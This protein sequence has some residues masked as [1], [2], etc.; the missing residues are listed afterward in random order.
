MNDVM[1]PVAFDKLL[2]WIMEEYKEHKSIF[3]IAESNFFINCK[4]E[5][6]RLWGEKYETALGPA[7]GPHTQ[8]AQNIIAAYLTG[9]RFFELKTIQVMDELDIPKPCIEA[10]HEGYNTEWSTEL[11][12]EEAYQE[13]VK[14]W[15]ILHY[16]K[17][18]FG[19]RNTPESGFIFNMSVGYDL[20]GIKTAKI[21]NFIENLKD[22]EH[23]AFFNQCQREMFGIT[24]EEIR[25]PA[26]ISRSITL[27]TMHGCPPEEQESICRYLI[28][29][30]KLHTYVKLNPTLLGY[31]FVGKT[32]RGLGFTCPLKEESFANDLQYEPAKKMINSLLA[33]AEENGLTFGVKL[34]N[35]LPVRNAKAVLPGDE[36]YMSGKALYPL[37]INLA[38][39][40]YNDFGEKLAISYCGGAEADNIAEIL[41]CGIRP[42]TLATNL[43]KPGG[44]SRL[45]QMAEIEVLTKVPGKI[46]KEKLN[47]LAGAVL[48]SF[49]R[50]EKYSHQLKTAKALPLWDC[51]LASCSSGCPIG[52]DIP[53]YISKVRAG[54]FAEAL[55]IILL[56]NPLPHITGYICE[57]PCRLHC[58]RIDYDTPLQIRELKKTAALKG[59][60]EVLAKITATPAGNKKAAIIGAGP[61][62]LAAAYFL[63]KHGIAVSVFEKESKAGG[64]VRNVIP[65]FRLTEEVIDKDVELIKRTGVEINYNQNVDVDELIKR[66]YEYILLAVGA[67]KSRKLEL[68]GDGNGLISGLDFLKLFKAGKIEQFRGKRV[69]ITGGGNSAMDSARAAMRLPGVKS[70]DLVYRRT[71]K[72]MPADREEFDNAISEGVVFKELLQPVKLA[73]N[74]LYCQ[75]MELDKADDHRRRGVHPSGAETVEMAADLVISAIGEEVDREFLITNGINLINNFNTNRENVYLLGDAFRG[76]SSVVQAMADGMKVAEE[77]L[78]KEGITAYWQENIERE[79]DIAGLVKKKAEVSDFTDDMLQESARCLECDIICNKCVEVCPNRANIAVKV[80]S[81]EF[82]NYNQIIHLDKLCNKCGNCETFCPYD[83]A[84]YKDKF[85]L[86]HE[87]KAFVE[88]DNNG[89]YLNN[90]LDGEYRIGTKTGR[91]ND[92]DTPGEILALLK[93]IKEKYQYLLEI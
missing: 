8:C 44:Y 35:T 73:N 27:S 18:A 49:D 37:T 10:E 20:A 29:E 64:L 19:L 80:T 79:T 38:A 93:A 92:N 40:L 84:P 69:V 65:E 51:A 76:P 48:E 53:A 90:K 28:K 81:K 9:A 5:G 36:M 33:C 17:Y 46:D 82:K 89:I 30:K 86:F 85:T 11:K 15:F 31:E 63:R 39:K 72:E 57:H 74:E 2:K 87:R 75:P 56:R 3:G 4:E 6:Y 68:A 59:Y 78:D 67:G 50:Y 66:G 43:L 13:Y 12:V 32:L 52:Q 42:V 23:D 24:G 62:G 88:S 14:A 77:I 55:E 16:L 47:I 7:A 34:S 71:E 61:A 91:L 83:G 1:K 21:D 22:A 58:T 45:R 60:D 70:V 26:H 25:I 54:K 41:S